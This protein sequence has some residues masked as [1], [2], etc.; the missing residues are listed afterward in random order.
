MR[1]KKIFYKAKYTGL[2]KNTTLISIGLESE[3]GVTFY[4]EFTDYDRAS[5]D[6]WIKKNIMPKLRLTDMPEGTL[7][8]EPVISDT[9]SVE[10]KGDRAHVGI[11]LKEWFKQ[12]PEVE[13]WG[14]CMS[15]DWILF[16]DIFSNAFN[17]PENIYYIPF[18]I[19]TLFKENCI[20]P[21]ISRVNFINGNDELIHNALYDA[22]VIRGCHEKIE[23]IKEKYNGRA[24]RP[25]FTQRPLFEHS[26]STNFE[27]CPDEYKELLKVWSTP[28]LHENPQRESVSKCCKDDK[29]HLRLGSDKC[30]HITLEAWIE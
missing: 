27:G 6:S 26:D 14:D 21:D 23:L 17:I 3:C 7:K 10:C 18:D 5:V 13:I 4:A 2:H 20:N 15:Y 11:A 12:F 29:I 28:T 19:C 22:H 16:A 25:S 24:T 8:V 1:R 9:K 30:R